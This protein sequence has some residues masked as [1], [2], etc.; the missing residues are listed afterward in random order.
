MYFNTATFVPYTRIIHTLP[1]SAPD[2]I[3]RKDR[4]QLR[5]N[6]EVTPDLEL[7]VPVIQA[8]GA[9]SLPQD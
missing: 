7:Q 5:G 1:R 4:L 3:L 8:A 9:L 2:V 6:M